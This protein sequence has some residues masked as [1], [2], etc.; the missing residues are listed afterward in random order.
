MSTTT[1]VH[2]MILGPLTAAQR[3][4]IMRHARTLSMPARQLFRRMLI[5][6]Q[7]RGQRLHLT[8][9]GCRQEPFDQALLRFL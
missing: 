9:L 5:L 3:S 2:E 8:S 4:E 1:S 6:R 7:D